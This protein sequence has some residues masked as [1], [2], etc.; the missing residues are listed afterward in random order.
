MPKYF[1]LDHKFLQSRVMDPYIFL[2]DPDPQS[3]ITDP[4][5]PLQIRP[6]SD[7][8]SGNL[9]KNIANRFKNIKYYKIFFFSEIPLNIW[10]ILRIRIQETIQ[11]RIH[12]TVSKEPTRDPNRLDITFILSILVLC[13]LECNSNDHSVIATGNTYRQIYPDRNILFTRAK[14]DN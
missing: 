12:N 10:S 14:G 9:K 11:L 6:D 8:T 13:G 3:W 2:S 7:C 4:G 5:G 1:N